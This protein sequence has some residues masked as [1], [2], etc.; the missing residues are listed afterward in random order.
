M[1]GAAGWRLIF[2]VN[3]PVGI[4][5]IAAG[6][7]FIPRSQ[8]LQKRVA[9]DWWGLGLFA[10][11]IVALLVAV[12][13]GNRLGWGSAP[14]VGLFAV[15]VGLRGGVRRLGAAGPLPD[16]RPLAVLAPGLLGRDRQRVAVLPRPVRHA[17]RGPVRARA[18]ARASARPGSGWS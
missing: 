18:R 16:A 15:T 7:L 6:V 4:L 8:H 17:V 1:L 13:F 3:V 2:W 5:G 12:S 9:F 10:P 14:I 11:A